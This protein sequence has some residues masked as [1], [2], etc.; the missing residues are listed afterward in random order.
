MKSFIK[1]KEFEALNIGFALDEG[2]SSKNYTLLVF[3]QD[4]RPWRKFTYKLVSWQ[5]FHGFHMHDMVFA[6]LGT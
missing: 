2:F 4:K 6:N 3:S 1:T 5:N